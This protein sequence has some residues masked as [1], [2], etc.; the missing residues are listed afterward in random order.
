MGYSPWGRKESDTT[1]ATCMHTQ[2]ETGILK[3]SRDHTGKVDGGLSEPPGLAIR[4]PLRLPRASGKPSAS[5]S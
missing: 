1:E 3:S 2:C 5:V 4:N